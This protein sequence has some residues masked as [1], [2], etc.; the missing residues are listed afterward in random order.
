MV[1]GGPIICRLLFLKD[2]Y[3]K[4]HFQMY[5]IKVQ[6]RMLARALSKISFLIL[7]YVG[8]FFNTIWHMSIHSNKR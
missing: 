8:C 2:T 6:I 1:I 5:I 4:I 7:G 3:K